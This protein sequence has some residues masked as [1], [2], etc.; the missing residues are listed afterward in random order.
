MNKPISDMTLRELQLYRKHQK[1]LD[2]AKKHQMKQLRKRVMRAQ[3]L[4][5]MGITPKSVKKLNQHSKI[6]LHKLEGA[7]GKHFNNVEY[8]LD[9]VDKITYK[10][11]NKIDR[12]TSVNSDEVDE[13]LLNVELDMLQDKLDDKLFLCILDDPSL[14]VPSHSVTL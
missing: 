5:D 6:M 9:Q 8:R 11:G 4:K 14:N 10:V 12:V 1:K 3:L 7:L 13:M 2:K